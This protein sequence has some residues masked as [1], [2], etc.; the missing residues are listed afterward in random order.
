MILAFRILMLSMTKSVPL[1]LY[2]DI[3]RINPLIHAHM[4]STDLWL[5]A[6]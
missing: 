3:Q 2:F 4:P 6:I 1:E 5:C